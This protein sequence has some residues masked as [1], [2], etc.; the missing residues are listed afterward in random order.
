MS[1]ASRLQNHRF[2]E[3]PA[4]VSMLLEQ[5]KQIEDFEERLDHSEDDLTKIDDV[6]GNVLTKSK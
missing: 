4:L 2:V 6:D 5:Q 3:I 1:D